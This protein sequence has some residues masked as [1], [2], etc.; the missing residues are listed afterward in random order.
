[1]IDSKS[2][3]IGAVHLLRCTDSGSSENELERLRFKMLMKLQDEVSPKVWAENASYVKGML[4]SC[5]T[6]SDLRSTF[7][8][9][10]T[11]LGIKQTTYVEEA[12]EDAKRVRKCFEDKLDLSPEAAALSSGEAGMDLGALSIPDLGGSA[13]A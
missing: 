12:R 7:S 2:S 10:K 13:A 11:Y 9:L 1:M 3:P 4:S 8:N 5:S 6:V